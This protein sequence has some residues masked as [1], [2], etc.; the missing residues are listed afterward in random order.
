MKEKLRQV[1]AG[2]IVAFGAVV[3]ISAFLLIFFYGCEP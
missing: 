1:V 2:F 3:F